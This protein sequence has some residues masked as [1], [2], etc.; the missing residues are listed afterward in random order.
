MTTKSLWGA[1][2]LSC[3]PALAAAQTPSVKIGVLNDQTTVYSD[4]QGIGSGSAAQFAVDDYAEK[5]GVKA[6]VVSADHQNK[7][8]VGVSLARNWYEVQGV[9]V[10]MDLPNSAIALGVNVLARDPNKAF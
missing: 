1:L 6:E 9:D 10:V 8:D 3:L 5:L 4:S 7:V 2:L